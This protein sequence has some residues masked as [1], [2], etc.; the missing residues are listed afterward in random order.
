MYP[1]FIPDFCARNCTLRNPLALSPP[2]EATGLNK[3]LFDGLQ[4][5]LGLVPNLVQK[6]ANSPAAL[7]AYLGFGA[8][9]GEGKL[10]GRQREQIAVAVVNTNECDYCLSAHNLLGSLQG[11]TKP[12][13]EAPSGAVCRV[14]GREGCGDPAFRRQGCERAGSP[15]HER[16]GDAARRRCSDEEIVE[17]I[18]TVAMNIF[19]NYFNHIAGTEIDFPVV[20]AAE[21]AAR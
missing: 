9:L 14:K 11:L 5:K 3:Q 8:L 4:S 20:H 10:T 2:S 7:T 16:S 13:L 21:R 12:E 1:A 6:L 18:A 15:A 17:V 19:T